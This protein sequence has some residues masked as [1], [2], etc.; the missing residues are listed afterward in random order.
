MVALDRACKAFTDGG[1]LHVDLLADCKDIRHGH[2]GTGCIF[3]SSISVDLEF[4]D[5]FASF[6]A[7][8]SKVSS[9]WLGHTR[10]FA[11]AKR[12][13]QGYVAVI[14]LGLDLGDTVV[15]YI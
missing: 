9:H 13:L 15:R 7:C 5:D 1:A 11:R 2:G 12:N 4:L 10:R 14:F 8:F 6:D 3:G